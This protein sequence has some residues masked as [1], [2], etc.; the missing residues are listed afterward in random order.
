MLVFLNEDYKDLISYYKKLSSKD[1]CVMI[2]TNEVAV[3]YF[4]K[5]HRL[6]NL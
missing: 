5:K 3:P 2:F 4:L 1:E 6:K